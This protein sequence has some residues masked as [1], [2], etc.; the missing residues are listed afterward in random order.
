MVAPSLIRRRPG[1]RVKTD[2]RHAVMLARLLRSGD[3][4]PVWVPDE[5]H[6]ALRNLVQSRGDGKADALH[7]KH[8][9]SKFLRR[10]GASAR[11]HQGVV[12]EVSK[13]GSTD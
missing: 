2:Q 6:E 4:T 13:P 5:A 1:D 12:G 3:L 11:R 10:Q 8:R 7:A 9:L